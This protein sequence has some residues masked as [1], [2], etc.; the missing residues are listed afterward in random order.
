MK[1][2]GDLATALIVVVWLLIVATGFAALAAFKNV[3]GARGSEPAPAPAGHSG[4]SLALFV[5]PHCPCSR[6]SLAE[7][8][9]LMREAGP[10]LSARVVLVRPAGVPDGWER[11]ELWS[12][13][14]GIAG[15]RVDRDTGASEARR[16]G[17]A[18][19]GHAVLYDPQ[20]RVVFSGGLTRGRG[21]AGES[22]G[23]RAVVA[24]VRGRAAD[25]DAPVFGCPLAGATNCT[26]TNQGDDACRP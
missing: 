8:R 6:A 7:L 5:H 10:A 17:A 25:R 1:R 16:A 15:V 2:S 23:R 18:T 12:A 14:T 3:P 22:S 26:G 24:H 19:S 21:H 4:W 13:A 11:G 9:E 20:G